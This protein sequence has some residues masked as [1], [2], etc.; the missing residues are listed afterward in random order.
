MDDRICKVAGTLT[1]S[2]ITLLRTSKK[3]V[4]SGSLDLAYIAL[5][6]LRDA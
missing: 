3:P 5:L 1:C 4:F 2:L 6:A